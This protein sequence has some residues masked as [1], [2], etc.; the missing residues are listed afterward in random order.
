MLILGIDGP[1]RINWKCG[2]K[3]GH[4]VIPVGNSRLGSA[5]RQLRS[6]PRVKFLTPR[7]E[8]LEIWVVESG[9]GGFRGREGPPWVRIL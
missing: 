4:C 8:F 6:A 2:Y 7:L 9:T 5:T 1:P 3:E